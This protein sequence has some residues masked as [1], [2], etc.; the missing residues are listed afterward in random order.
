[1][2]RPAKFSHDEILDAARDAVALHGTAA[3]VAQVCALAGAPTG[4]VYH[5]F[6]TR[7]HLFVTLWLRAV[8]RFQEGL[9]EAAALPDADEA[10]AAVAV[11]IP[12]W[13]REHPAEAKALTLYR[14]QVLVRHAPA[15]LVDEVRTLNE[16][17]D[18]AG[19]ALCRRRYGRT[20][21]HLQALVLTAV[22]QCPYGLVRPYVGGDVPRW[23]D[24][25]VLAASAAILALGDG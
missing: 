24:D 1:M 15:E 19:R 18:A 21:K 7:E 14:Q 20:T 4:S 5:R 23:L 3:T 25:A 17:V 9:L 2:A 22:R 8:R 13:C 11:H 10:L 12:R 16:A 6:P